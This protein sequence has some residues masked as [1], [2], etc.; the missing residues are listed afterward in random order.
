MFGTRHLE[1]LS[2]D[3]IRIGATVSVDVSCE[4]SFPN[5]AFAQA[6]CDVAGAVPNTAVNERDDALSDECPLT[7]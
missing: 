4:L 1:N 2:A 5:S 3:N 6:W 7:S